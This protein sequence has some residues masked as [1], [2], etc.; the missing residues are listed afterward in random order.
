MGKLCREKPTDETIWLKARAERGIGGSE[1]AAIVGMSPWMTANE[2][3]QLKTG[4]AEPKDISDD[5]FV[6]QGHRMEHAIRELYKAYHPSYKV[7]YN[8]FHLLYQKERPWLFATLDGE[9]ILPDKRKGILECKSSTPVGKAGWA[10]WDCR[11]PDHYMIQLLH[12]MLATGFDFADL[13]AL[14][15][16]QEGDFVLRTYHFERADYEEDLNWLLEKEEAFWETVQNRTLPPMTL[17]I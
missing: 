8:R 2:L 12:Q 15:I 13:V 16:N 3:W 7:K 14:L 10:K 11:I 17:V 6:Q 1:A 4:S 5:P 9:V